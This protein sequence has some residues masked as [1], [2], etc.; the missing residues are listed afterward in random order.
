MGEKVPWWPSGKDAGLRVEKARVRFPVKADSEGNCVG[1]NREKGN[2][3]SF[4][5]VAMIK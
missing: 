5:T 4:C 1:Q 3:N 2:G